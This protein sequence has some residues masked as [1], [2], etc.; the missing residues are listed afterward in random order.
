MKGCCK[1]KCINQFKN[2]EIIN[3]D[4]Q[5]TSLE[6]KAQEITVFSEL[7]MRIRKS[8][9]RKEQFVFDFLIMKDNFEKIKVCQQACYTFHLKSTDWIQKKQL[10]AKQDNFTFD[11]KR[12]KSKGQHNNY[13]KEEQL[14][15]FM[16]NYLQEYTYPSLKNGKQ[17]LPACFTINDMYKKYKTIS[18]DP[19][20]QSKFFILFHNNYPQLK[21]YKIYS[22]YCTLCSLLKKYN[23]IKR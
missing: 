15:T 11:E 4:Q 23:Q 1:L 21:K 3:Y 16:D 12:G 13:D 6:K 14:L 7:R 22:N 8:L 9:G 19:Y 17:L 20:S 18:P 2:D 5:F 10:M